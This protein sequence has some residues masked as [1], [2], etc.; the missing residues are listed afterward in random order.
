MSSGQTLTDFGGT[1][2]ASEEPASAVRSFPSEP[3][4]ALKERPGLLVA[5]FS[6]NNAGPAPESGYGRVTG[7]Q[8]AQ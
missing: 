4:L 3:L 2:G 7:Q 8:A 1:T 5:R 6:D